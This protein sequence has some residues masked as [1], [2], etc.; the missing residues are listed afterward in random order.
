MAEPYQIQFSADANVQIISFSGHLVINHI[1]KI[2][3]SAKTQLDYEK[4]VEV[5]ITNCDN[6][7]ITF[8][9]FLIALQKTWMQ[10]G[11]E[12]SVK[13]DI[14]EDLVRLIENSGFKNILK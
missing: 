8:I 1:E 9:Q 6:I 2:V 14:K 7:D 11:L 12:F 4:S 10:N 13:S 5:V 3:N